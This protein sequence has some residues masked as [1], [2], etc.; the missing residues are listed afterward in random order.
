V[1]VAFMDQRA[2]RAAAGD[3]KA[4]QLAAA[5]RLTLTGEKIDGRWKIDAVESK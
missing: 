2:T 5:G 3:D 1:V 4:T